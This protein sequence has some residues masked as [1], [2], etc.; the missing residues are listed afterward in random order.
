[1]MAFLELKRSGRK[2]SR[3]VI[4]LAAAD[5]ETGGA[6]GVALLL[7]QHPDLFEGVGFVLNEGGSTTTIVDKV[8]Y[9]GIETSQKVPLWLRISV[10]RRPSHSAVPPADGGSA[11]Q[12]MPVLAD[13]LSMPTPYRVVPAAQESLRAFSRTQPGRRGQLLSDVRRYVNA[14]EF[15]Q[16]VP[17]GARSVLH[18]TIALTQ[19]NAGTG[20]N[21]MPA[22]A[23]ATLDFRLLP[24]VPPEVTIEKV[25]ALVA[26]R[27][28]VEILLKGEPTIAS[29]TNT[30]LFAILSRAMKAAEPS[31]VVGPV[32]SP[33]TSDSRFFRARGIVAYG[34]SPFKVNY[35]D[36]DTVHGTDE[37]IRSEFFHQ[38][39]RLMKRVTR[40]FCTSPS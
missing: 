28:D 27:A 22:S 31:S 6:R 26:K 30:P 40:E 32:F 39:V 21:M 35:Y 24:D 7:K 4:F 16:L 15:A 8:S 13:L 29:P 36:A 34:I 23:T 38:G 19:L 10:R 3:D 12:L 11:A 33:G 2:L 25:R 17:E 1:L 14:P 20:A 18:D 9:W 37:R 5:E